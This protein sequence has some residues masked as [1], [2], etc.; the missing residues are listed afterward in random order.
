MKTDLQETLTK[1][2]FEY[3]NHIVTVRVEIVNED[4]N[5]ARDSVQYLNDSRENVNCFR[6][7][8]VSAWKPDDK[9]IRMKHSEL[10]LETYA[11]L[12]VSKETVEEPHYVFFTKTKTK[13]QREIPVKEHV[14]TAVEGILEKL[15][16]FYKFSRQNVDVEIEIAME[17]LHAETSWIDIE[18]QSSKIANRIDTLT[19]TQ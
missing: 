9:P 2:Q 7:I 13:G 19:N 3:G 5:Q 18:N 11:A 15:D 14:D 6:K 8:S 16:E 12:G 1:E 10:Y 17:E 4:F